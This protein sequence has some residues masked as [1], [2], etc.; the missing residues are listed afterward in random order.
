M[1]KWRPNRLARLGIPHLRLAF[2][3]PRNEA[4]AIRA[5]LSRIHDL[6]A[7]KRRS[8]GTSSS[9]VPDLRCSVPRCGDYAIAIRAEF[10]GAHFTVVLELEEKLASARIPNSRFVVG[11]SGKY[12]FSIRTEFCRKKPPAMLER[13]R[14]RLAGL[15]V[16]HSGGAVERGGDH[17]LPILAKLT[18]TERSWVLKRACQSLSCASIPDHPASR[19]SQKPRPVRAELGTPQLIIRLNR[20]YRWQRKTALGQSRDQTLGGQNISGVLP[21]DPRQMRHCARRIGR[22]KIFRSLQFYFKPVST[23]RWR[24]AASSAAWRPARSASVWAF[25]S[26][27]K[28]R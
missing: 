21:Q 22:E 17:P 9:R 10:S 8:D 20:R 19:S 15:R 1:L 2:F 14:H 16:P 11:G 3:A 23:A 13:P 26:A 25:F 5:K 4:P 12:P 27:V 24:C 18:V 6:S 28:A 7:T